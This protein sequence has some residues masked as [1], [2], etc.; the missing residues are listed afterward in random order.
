MRSGH[1]GRGVGPGQHFPRSPRGVLAHM[2]ATN[3]CMLEASHTDTCVIL[4]AESSRSP[5]V[6]GLW[7]P[8]PWCGARAAFSKLRG[9]LAEALHLSEQTNLYA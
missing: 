7:P 2:G 9:V 3:L 5:G 6:H 4:G 8:G 1:Q